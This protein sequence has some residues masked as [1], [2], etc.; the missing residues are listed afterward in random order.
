MVTDTEQ[1]E[2]RQ[3]YLSGDGSRLGGGEG[4]P[5]SCKERIPTRQVKGK[6]RSTYVRETDV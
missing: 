6:Q 1:K 5:G 2:K 3:K 4:R